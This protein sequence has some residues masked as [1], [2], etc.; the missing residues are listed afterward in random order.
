[1]AVFS[2]IDKSMFACACLVFSHLRSPERCTSGAGVHPQDVCGLKPR[3]RQDHLLSLHLCHGH[4]EHPLCVC[5]CQRH[6][7]TAQ[8]QRV[9]SGVRAHVR[10]TPPPH[11]T[12]A[13]LPG[14]VRSTPHALHSTPCWLSLTHTRT[15]THTHTH[16]QNPS[17]CFVFFPV[18]YIHKSSHL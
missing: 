10:R 18:Q 7:P 17:C 4:W 14:S 12:N 13:H 8:S 5:S 3:Q 16:Q 11:C 2:L 15:H 6:H 1:M 9:Q